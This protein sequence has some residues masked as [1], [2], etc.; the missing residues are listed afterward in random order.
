ML[1]SYTTPALVSYIY[2]SAHKTVALSDR[3]SVVHT[4]GAGCIELNSGL[5][6]QLLGQA[7]ILSHYV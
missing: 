7:I 1:L 4:V 2:F 6:I 3:V 5:I